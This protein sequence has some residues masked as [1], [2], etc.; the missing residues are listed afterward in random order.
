MHSID[1]CHLAFR[2]EQN[3]SKNKKCCDCNNNNTDREEAAFA[4]PGDGVLLTFKRSRHESGVV[5]AETE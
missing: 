1:E 4:F 5:A 3:R 2:P